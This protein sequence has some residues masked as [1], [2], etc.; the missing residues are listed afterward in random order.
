MKAF[1]FYLT[2]FKACFLTGEYMIFDF[3]WAVNPVSLV[4]IWKRE[5]HEVHHL[6]GKTYALKRKK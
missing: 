5:G 6:G 2:H 3:S 4:E 1:W